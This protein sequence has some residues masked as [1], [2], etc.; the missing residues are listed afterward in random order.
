MIAFKDNNSKYDAEIKLCFD[1]IKDF[2]K[3]SN[4]DTEK[5]K[6]LKENILKIDCVLNNGVEEEIVNCN[7]QITAEYSK[8]L[9]SL[10]YGFELI[11]YDKLQSYTYFQKCSV[12]RNMG[13]ALIDLLFKEKGI[14][15]TEE[16][17]KSGAKYLINKL[18]EKLDKK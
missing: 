12:L 6:R 9:T 18:K 17:L 1:L 5:E 3:V 10:T 2:L 16:T 7:L 8:T 13:L 15:F 11:P 14:R 4:T